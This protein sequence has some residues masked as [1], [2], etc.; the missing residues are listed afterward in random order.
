MALSLIAAVLFTGACGGDSEK[1]A[2]EKPGTAVAASRLCA[3]AFDAPAAEALRRL[4]GTDRFDEA[5]GAGKAGEPAA[6]SLKKAVEHLHDAY[7][8]RSACWVYKTG[9]DSGEPL[10]EIRFSASPG[11]PSGTR[12]DSGTEKVTY[13]V[14]RFAQVGPNGADLFFQCSTEAPAGDAYIGDTKYVKAELF[15][16]RGHMRGDSIDRD[17]M[18]ILNSISRRVAQTAGC[19]SEAD[20]PGAVPSR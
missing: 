9:D 5:T 3:G 15:S 7:R 6:F 17:R 13:P 4:A 2:P 19:A 14:G 1:E 11:Y 10:L 8:E 12:K 18:V 20:L 16:P